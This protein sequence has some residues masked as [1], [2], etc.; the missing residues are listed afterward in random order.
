MRVRLLRNLAQLDP[1]WEDWMALYRANGQ[2]LF[3][4]PELHRIWWEHRGLKLGWSPLV[5]TGWQDNRLVAVASLAVKRV[6]LLRILEW[7]NIEGFD[8]PSVLMTQDANAGRLWAAVRHGGGF[9]L[10]CLRSVRADDPVHRTLAD[11]AQV[12]GQ[13]SVTHAIDLLD[14]NVRTRFARSS[15]GTSSRRWKE[16]RL[17]E[18]RGPVV[19]R[20]AT[21]PDEIRRAIDI[22]IRFKSEWSRSRRMDTLYLSEGIGDYFQE[23]AMAAARDGTLHL[24]TLEA[25]ADILAAHLGFVSKD[26]LYHYVSSYDLAA[27]KLAP[28]RVIMKMLVQ[29]AIENGLPRFDFLRGEAEYKTSL[30][31]SSR[32]LNDFVFSHGM[33][34][35][36]AQ[37]AYLRWKSQELGSPDDLFK[38]VR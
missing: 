2:S 13:G 9:N 22:L 23:L 36:V 7:A 37:K 15:T 33:L 20:L 29:W 12:V 6:R 4:N 10:A 35:W 32:R 14:P 1:V 11:F 19:L 16:V 18:Q 34:G 25:G 28:G 17:M 8:Y 38:I 3:Q 24:S 30:G 27:A 5:A 21:Q 31:T 26:G